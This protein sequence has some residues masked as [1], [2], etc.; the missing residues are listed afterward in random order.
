MGFDPMIYDDHG[1]AELLAQ[2]QGPPVL[3]ADAQITQRLH[4]RITIARLMIAVAAV[5]VMLALPAALS[6]IAIALSIPC[7]FRL[8]PRATPRTYRP[9]LGT[10]F[11]VY[12]GGGWWY[13][14]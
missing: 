14:G 13:R 10:N 7:L 5:A 8:S 2:K 4:G 3:T 1:I 12:L 6:V 9:F 11:D